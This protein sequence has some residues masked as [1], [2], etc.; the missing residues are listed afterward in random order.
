MLECTVPARYV[1]PPDATM[2]D[3]VFRNAEL[4]ADHVAFGRRTGQAW[5]EVS[6]KEFAG[7]VTALAA[8]LIAAGVRTGQRVALFASTSFEWMLSDAAI[9]AAGAVTVPIYETSS[10][11]QVE[12][13]IADSGAVLAIV[14]ARDQAGIV[15]RLRTRLPALREVF[16]FDGAG[17]EELVARGRDVPEQEVQARRHTV[18]AASLATIV[19]TSGTTGRPKGCAITHANLLSEVNNIAL[20]DGVAEHVLNETRSTLLFLPLAHILARVIQLAAVHSRVRLG[21]TADM[22]NVAPQLAEF[23]PTSVLSVPRVFEKIYNTAE[24]T[25]VA[26]GKGRIF[27]MA[28]AT[29]VDHSNALDHGGPGLFLRARHALFDR[30]VY[31]R[32]R[33]ALG[34]QV[35]YSVSG[36]APLGA[37][38]G[39]FFRGIGVTVLE[40]YGLTETCAGATLNLPG[41]QRIGSVGRPL[42]GVS[43]RIAPDGEV[44]IKGGHVFQGYWQDE[45][46]T[47]E[48]FDDDG[49]FLTG[50]LGELDEGGFLTITGRKKDLIVTSAG[51]NVA[52][53]VLEDRLRA[54]WLV[55]QCVVVGDGR[56]FIAALVTIDETVLT[57]WKRERGK[58]EQA[59]VADLGQDVDLLA[60]VQ[61]AVDHANKA[62]SA[63]EAI[64]SF[65]VLAADFSVETGELT[66]TLKVKRAAVVRSLHAEIEAIYQTRL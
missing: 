4:H 59:S 19:Y 51:K 54:H 33:A 18:T 53:A 41:A 14:G 47:R 20:A 43:I 28:A 61:D 26:D 39:H 29:A 35:E 9:W 50:D 36:G 34:G 42:P 27:A 38:L 1:P 8:G 11:E 21:H 24:H 16:T 58:P 46:S 57:G 10:S 62:V 32:L 45:K 15:D 17:L 66:P 40:G 65:R 52:P 2:V 12:W 48:V 31:G 55:S 49:W 5:T 44:M 30:L 23:R 3:D 64:K 63:A 7:E 13:I 60:E 6:C 37:R 25:A 22:R 56:P